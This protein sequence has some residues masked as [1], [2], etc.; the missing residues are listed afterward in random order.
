[1][2]VNFENG[3]AK[4]NEKRYDHMKKSIR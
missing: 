4:I 2:T 3:N 1:M